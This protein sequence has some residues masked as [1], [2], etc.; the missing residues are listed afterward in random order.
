M[1][2][3]LLLVIHQ[4]R[5][6]L[7]ASMYRSFLKENPEFWAIT[8]QRVLSYWD[9]YYR[10]VWRREDYVGFQLVDHFDSL[11]IHENRGLLEPMS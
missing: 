4:N 3:I 10:A 2:E 1:V 8:K 9:C 5:A 11:L 7:D 6:S